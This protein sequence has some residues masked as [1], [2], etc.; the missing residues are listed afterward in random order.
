MAK[1]EYSPDS[2]RNSHPP[3]SMMFMD[4]SIGAGLTYRAASAAPGHASTA[5]TRVASFINVT[6]NN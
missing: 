1:C 4:S 2:G 3:V 6:P 5:A